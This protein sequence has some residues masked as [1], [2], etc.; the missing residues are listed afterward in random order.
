MKTY[1]AQIQYRTPDGNLEDP[2]LQVEAT[3]KKQARGLAL[4]VATERSNGK[5]AFVRSVVGFAEP[6]TTA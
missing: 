6:V 5:G 2:W 1:F 4:Q 3:S